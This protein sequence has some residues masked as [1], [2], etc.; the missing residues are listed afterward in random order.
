MDYARARRMMV[1]AQVRPNDVTDLNLQAAF[2]AVPRELFVPPGAEAQAYADLEPEAA[3]GRALLRPRDLAKLLQALAPKAGDRALEI[4]G[5]TGY[6]TA[7]MARMGAHA[8]LLEPDPELARA[9]RAALQGAGAEGALVVSTDAISGWPD[10][11][12]YDVIVLN[13]AAE[14]VPEA[15]LAQLADGGRLGM[16]VRDGPAGHARIYTR[17]GAVTAYRVVFDAAPPVAPGL[18]KPKAFAF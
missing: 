1:D 7:L 17:S 18:S 5:A 10:A 15:W 16:I 6:T 9:A 3:P 12:P 2:L 8:T 4:A 13:G 11:A 14:I